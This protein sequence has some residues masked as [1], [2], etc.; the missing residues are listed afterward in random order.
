MKWSEA[1]ATGI[2][3][4]DE[5]HRMLFTIVDDFR[6]AL[7]EGR[8]VQTYP[9]LLD[10]LADYSRAHFAFEEKCMVEYRCPAAEQNVK[11]HAGYVR[12]LGEYRSRYED[13]GF[14]PQDARALVDTLDEW[15][16]S[17]IGRIDIR[18]RESAPAG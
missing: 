16:A 11:A 12:L 10:M 14:H 8:G 3:K 1:F 9:L 4:I 5:Q 2:E 13:S 7:D 17:H 15:L 6:L 18:L